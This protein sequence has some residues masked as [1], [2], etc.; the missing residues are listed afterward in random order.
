METAGQN[1]FTRAGTITPLKDGGLFL[2]PPSPTSKDDVL[3]IWPPFYQAL[4]LR[5]RSNFPWFVSLAMQAPRKQNINDSFQIL[6]LINSVHVVHQI[7][8]V[9]HNP[10]PLS[11]VGPHRVHFLWPFSYAYS[12]TRLQQEGLQH[13]QR[14]VCRTREVTHRASYM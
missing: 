13:V 10:L 2:Y 9:L 6:R 5:K 11:M 1:Y 7:G 4:K 8:G 3:V 12:A 14:A